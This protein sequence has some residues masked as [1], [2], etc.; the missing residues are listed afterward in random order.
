[1]G[2]YSGGLIIGT[3][4]LRLRFGGLFSG[5]PFFF[6][7]GG[8]L[9]I[10]ILWCV[11]YKMSL[12]LTTTTTTTTTTL[13]LRMTIFTVYMPAISRAILGRQMDV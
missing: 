5:G 7:G 10:G 4:Y 2:L 6:F 8:G 9:I 1:M 11:L 13:L 12:I 3:G